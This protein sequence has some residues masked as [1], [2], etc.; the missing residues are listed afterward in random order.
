MTNLFDRVQH[1]FLFDIL[2][3][4][5]FCSTFIHWILACVSNPWIAQLIN[6]RS[7]GF[8]EVS[9]GL[10][11]GFPLSHPLYII[12]AKSLSRKLEAE[13]RSGNLLRIKVAKGVRSINHSWF[14]GDTL[15]LEGASTIMATRFKAVLDFFIRA[16]GGMIS[17]R[18]S[19]IYA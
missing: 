6:G 14:V 1:S 11:Q 16:L 15:L 4:L 19:Q 8:F 13:R 9:R 2:H 17:N 10:H 7:S 3:K 18:K 5:E 12:M